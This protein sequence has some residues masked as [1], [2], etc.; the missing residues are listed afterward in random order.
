M[1]LSRSSGSESL[2]RNM[3][4]R[5]LATG[6]LAVLPRESTGSPFLPPQVRS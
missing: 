5:F 6:A 4:I 1:T 3:V 2:I